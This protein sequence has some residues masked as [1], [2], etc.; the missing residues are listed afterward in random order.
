MD[1]ALPDVGDGYEFNMPPGGGET[2]HSASDQ[3]LNSSF[4]LDSQEEEHPGA[5]LRRT[6]TA[7]AIV[8]DR[9]TE[10]ARRDIISNQQDYLENMRAQA[11]SHLNR[12]MPHQARKNAEYWIF[13]AGLNSV[14]TEFLGLGELDQLAAL[15]SGSQLLDNMGLSIKLT[16]KKRRSNAAEAEDDERRVRAR[17][18]DEIEFPR[19]G[20]DDYT[21]APED[22]EH[23]REGGREL[24]DPSSA[25]P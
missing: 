17:L 7:K 19:N 5:P 4:I 3:D 8:T 21:L 25:M 10:M 14:G 6:K 1:L 20:D 13:G 22:I 2:G 18:N 16:P 12:R 11:L 9:K 15:F 24:D 23:P